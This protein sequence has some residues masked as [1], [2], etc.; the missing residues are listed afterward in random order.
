VVGRKS[1]ALRAGYS[2]ALLSLALAACSGTVNPTANTDLSATPGKPSASLSSSSNVVAGGAAATL[3]WSSTDAT[4]CTAS[5]GWSGPLAASG[6]QSTGALSSNATYTITCSGAGGTSTP[7][8][9]TVNV[10]PT[11][12]LSAN[13]MSVPNGGSSTLSWRS[14]NATSCSASG[15]WSGTLTANGSANVGPLTSGTNFSIVCLGAGGSSTAT[16]VSVGILGGATASLTAN[17]TT[18]AKGGSSTLAWSSNNATTCTASGG[19]SGTLAPSG[20]QSSGP[21]S[22]TTTYSISCSGPGGASPTA[23][24]T[25][26]VPPVPTASISANPTTVSSGGSSTLTW[27]S[28]NATSCTA[29]GGWAGAL[30]TSGSKGTGAL[31]NTTTY[32][33]SCSGPGGTSATVSATVTVSSGSM[34]VSPTVA[35]LTQSQAQQFTATVPGGGGASWTVDNIGGGNSLVGLID[36]SGLYTPGSTVGMHTIVA[37]SNANNS[38]SASAKVYVTD[39]TGVLTYHNDAARQGANT[40]EYALSSGTLSTSSFGKLFSCTVDGAVYA[41]PLWAAG[42][43]FNGTTHNVVFVATAHDGLFAFDADSSPCVT[44]WQVNL[45][46]GAHG[47]NTG[48][49]T[50]P[51]GPSGHLVGAGDGD[52]TPEVGVIG[53]PVIDANAQILYVVSKSVSSDHSTFYQRLHAINLLTGQENSGSPTL[54][55]ATYPGTGDGGNMTTFKPG[56]ENQRSGLALVNGTVYIAW[57]AHEDYGQYYG[58]VVGYSYTGGTL[59]QTVVLNVTP[60]VHSGGIWMGGGAP[61]SDGSYLYLLTGNGFFDADSGSPPNNDYGDSLLQLNTSDLKVNQYFTP[62]DQ[63]NDNNVDADF[64][65]G[66][67]AVLAD[68]STV[69]LILGGGKDGDLY[70]LNRDSLGGYGVSP[71]I[72]KI[73]TG[74]SM[75]MTGAYWNYYYYM[76]GTGALQAYQLTL[77]GVPNL[78]LAGSTS[79]DFHFPGATPS[80]SANGTQNGIVWA[81]DNHTYCTNGS[82]GCGPAVLHA[83]TATSVTQELWN[84]SGAGDAAGN[85]V[86]FTVPTVA[87]GH[88]YVGTRG[89]S[90]TGYGSGELDVYGLKSN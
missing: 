36:S 15:G 23:S 70:L 1:N 35:A 32:S 73:P 56:V 85:A 83:Y 78:S 65:S 42:L 28:T 84:S 44:L 75:F 12:S 33:I 52:I 8:S 76:A 48:E 58:W 69:H 38:Q 37:T 57:A 34:S 24:A 62:S 27:S 9:A 22:T 49:T 64:G 81:L 43:V 10:V 47:A 2:C 77:A 40:Q 79:T 20:S 74:H 14:T 46:D 29:S 88:V 90:T 61:A 6:S 41:Q 50:V 25:V 30:A 11:A 89:S 13:P 67:T 3:T 80:V 26:T 63:V 60:N 5:G 31:A 71:P 86:K 82:T 87:N 39:L 55:T 17:P 54:I 16:S 21:I 59:N 66:G 53:T 51:S 72:Q 19:W 68:L 7:A 45:I 4:S 18:V